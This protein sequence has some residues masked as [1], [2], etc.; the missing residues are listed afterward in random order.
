MKMRS[1][2]FAAHLIV[3][4]M[5][6]PAATHACGYENPQTV[7]LGSL[8]WVYPDALHVRA[9]V[10][11]AEDDGLLPSGLTESSGPLAFYRAA[12]AVKKL[13][14]NLA[15]S[16][17]A[18]T[19]LAMSVVLIPQ[20]MW[21]RFDIGTEGLAVQNHAEGPQHGDLVIVT[22]EKVVRA[23]V[24]GKLNPETAEASGLMRFYGDPEEIANVRAALAKTDQA[25]GRHRVPWEMNR[26]QQ[27][28][29]AVHQSWAGGVDRSDGRSKRMTGFVEEGDLD[30]A[31][32]VRSKMR[33]ASRQK[34]F[35][36]CN[37]MSCR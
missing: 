21:T 17:P 4:G 33:Q 18:E 19:G 11:R 1:L 30:A 23:L 8:N 36:G 12:A 10:W 32:P 13:G 24:D 14:A 27:P 25:S 37:E 22:E 31:S 9:A 16:L 5:V 2:L 7:A 26:R 35:G 28:A 29:G 6:Q 34:S 15:G 3:A 20:V